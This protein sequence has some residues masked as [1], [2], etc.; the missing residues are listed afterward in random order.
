M[1]CY[2]FQYWEIPAGKLLPT[3]VYISERFRSNPY[4]KRREVPGINI[5]S[6]KF[7]KDPDDGMIDLG[8]FAFERSFFQIFFRRGQYNKVKVL[9]AVGLLVR[10]YGYFTRF[11]VLGKIYRKI[12]L[13]D[14]DL[15]FCEY[16]GL[17]TL[18]TS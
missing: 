1:I 12:E 8:K 10:S 3:S 5:V 4:R 2:R 16:I 15:K 7:R 17:I 14:F 9:A 11:L 13:R 6:S 18:S